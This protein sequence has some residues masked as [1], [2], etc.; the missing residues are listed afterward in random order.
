[1]SKQFLYTITIANGDVQSVCFSSLLDDDLP[2][3]AGVAGGYS[4]PSLV[5]DQYGRITSISSGSVGS[6]GGAPGPPGVP[7]EPG[8]DG[9]PGPPGRDGVQGS[10]GN[11]GADGPPIFLA[12][13]EGPEGPMGMAGASGPAGTQG[14]TGNT[15]ADGPATFLAAED[16]PEGPMGPPGGVGPAGLQGITGAAGVGS[17]GAVFFPEDLGET[18]LFPPGQTGL[19]TMAY[20]NADNV[21]ITNGSINV[22]NF[23]VLKNT[24]FFK[25]NTGSGNV[26][27]V[28]FGSPPFPSNQFITLSGNNTGDFNPVFFPDEPSEQNY[29]PPG[30][31]AASNADQVAGVHGSVAVTPGRQQRHPSACKAFVFFTVAGTTVTVQRSYN[32]ASVT[33]N[34]LGVYTVTFTTAF[35]DALYSVSITVGVNVANTFSLIARDQQTRAAGTFAFDV[36]QVPATTTLDDPARCSVLFFGN[37]V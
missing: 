5:V 1:M 16:G 6:G 9:W 37:L 29:F 3:V 31:P 36:I 10:T 33:R 27:I 17:G 30:M 34:S 15:G 2:R 4:N 19:G 35:S 26:L 22:F 20:Q 24:I 12:G 11:T 32:V 8:E 18:M 13:E 25:D 14:I 21:A 7:G 23:L 28:N